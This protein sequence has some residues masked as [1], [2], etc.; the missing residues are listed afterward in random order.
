MTPTGGWMASQSAVRGEVIARLRS[1]RRRVALAAALAVAQSLLA[2]AGPALAG[3]AIEAG[4]RAGDTAALDRAGLAFVAV[5]V[6]IPLVASWRIR[7]TAAVGEPFLANLRTDA[8]RA[9]LRLPLPQVERAGDGALLSRLTTDVDAL[10]QLVRDAVPSIVANGLLA[11]LTGV[12]LVIVAPPLGLVALVWVPVVVVAGRR[13]RARTRVLYAAERDAEA[14]VVGVV[15]ED[16]DGIAEVQGYR[17]EA[18][19]RA[20]LSLAADRVVATWGASTDARNRFFPVVTAA[21]VA[22][23]ASVLCAGAFLVARGVLGVGALAAAV[24]YLAQLFGPT[25][26][27][28]DWLDEVSGG[29][30]ALARIVGL[31]DAARQVPDDN[32]AAELP[33]RGDLEVVGVRIAY[34]AGAEVLAGVDLRVSAGERV[35]LVGATGAGKSTLALVVARLLRPDAGCVLV[36]D[37]DLASASAASARRRVVLVAQEGAALGRTVAAA[38]RVARP[39]ADDDEVATA[40]GVAG[41]GGVDPRC[42]VRALSAGE[43][44]LLALARVVLADPA[45]VILDEA[46]A[47]LDPGTEDEVEGAMRAALAG[48]AVLVIAHRPATALRADRVVVLA[49]GRVVEEGRP[50]ELLDRGGAFATLLGR[51]S[52]PT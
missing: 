19:R 39:D 11:V 42:E 47:R 37:V 20:R 4:V 46:T 33:S 45:V 3:Y 10:T 9:L 52:A 38:A 41:L 44:E 13:L 6:A 34:E 15:A 25:S 40:L 32:G 27:L 8:F 21:Q 22:A 2:L 17:R 5:L 43:R 16:L 26:E 23:T 35:A 30:A 14:A 1:A 29:G 50:Q 51:V 36:G 24:L 49:E 28:L 31:I 18:D 48:R 12:A 7:T